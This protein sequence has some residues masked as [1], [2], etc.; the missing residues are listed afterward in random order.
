[1][2]ISYQLATFFSIFLTE[3]NF[4][5][6]SSSLGGALLLDAYFQNN[7]KLTIESST[8][9]SCSATSGGAVYFRSNRE[10]LRGIA[11]FRNLT[12]Q[13][14][15]STD[16]GGAILLLYS[17]DTT[18][19]QVFLIN[20]S[21]TNCVSI[22]HGGAVA[23]R[24]LRLFVD[25]SFEISGCRFS[26]CKA[27]TGGAVY[28]NSQ[29]AS[30]VSNTTI[31]IR[32]NSFKLCTASFGGA[33]NLFFQ[34][35][36]D[37]LRL[38]LEVLSFFQCSVSVRGGALGITYN[39]AQKNNN[40][41]RLASF[42][43]C[44]AAMG[45]ALFFFTFTAETQ[46]NF[47]VL[48]S[49]FHNCTT[50]AGENSNGGAILVSRTSSIQPSDHFVSNRFSSCTSS[51]GGAIFSGYQRQVSDVNFI[52]RENNFVDC[53]ARDSSSALALGF[54][55]SENAQIILQGNTFMNCSFLPGRFGVV[56]VASLQRPTVAQRS[57]LLIQENSWNV[58]TDTDVLE[59]YQLYQYCPSAYI[60]KEQQCI[61]LFLLFIL[62]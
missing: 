44:S 41:V 13:S 55:V 54:T 49:D 60:L 38:L 32:N 2:V 6:S 37:R 58:G 22:N 36:T 26:S 46:N 18:S 15:S 9:F 17:N 43:D 53:I 40:T 23:V 27:F 39:G 12:F 56:E 8:F 42:T 11:S 62:F 25:G 5:Q 7:V 59:I 51:T 47:E 45:G 21:F 20:S 28:L 1:M 3:C 30:V 29:T 50:S 10:A 34:D 57:R 14:C 35:S 16:L 48:Q 52:L 31:W 24:L 4:Q 19:G 33:I 61:C